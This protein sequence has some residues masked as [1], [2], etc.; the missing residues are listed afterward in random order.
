MNAA[1]ALT[2]AQ[3]AIGLLRQHV[4]PTARIHGIV[5]HGGDAPNIVPAHTTGIWFVREQDITAL[6]E[7]EPRVVRCLE[8]G[9]LATG[10][11]L[12]LVRPSPV[13]SEFTPDAG[14]VAAYRRNA[15]AL[16]RRFADDD[17]RARVVGSTDMANV[18]LAMPAIHPMLGLGC[19]PVSNHQPEFA[20]FCATPVADRAVRDGALAM[21]WTC[22]DLAL[23]GPT[24]ERL[25]A[26]RA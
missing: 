24:R 6:A 20:A 2:V 14:M 23:D 15:E 1:D 13:Y 18:S 4:R 3:T 17:P 9:A 11:E 22:A 26:R 19:W 16:G 8:A 7:L 5:T 21:A 12:Q 10:C 25:T